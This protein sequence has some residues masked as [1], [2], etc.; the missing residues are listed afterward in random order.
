MHTPQFY[1]HVF[2]MGTAWTFLLPLAIV[3][4][5]FAKR[6]HHP[7]WFKLHRGLSVLALGLIVGAWIVG[8]TLMSTD[9]S[10]PHL[11][12]GTSAVF[13]AAIQPT[14]AWFRPSAVHGDKPSED[15]RE[16]FS[17]HAWVGRAAV[18]LGLSNVVIGFNLRGIGGLWI[19]PVTLPLGLIGVTYCVCE[20]K[21]LHKNVPMKRMRHV[22]VAPGSAENSSLLAGSV[23]AADLPRMRCESMRLDTVYLDD[24]NKVV[25]RATE[26]L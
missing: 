11:W 8:M 25:R 17:I 10:P 4:S 9:V 23:D 3:I 6:Y 13:L 12:V 22:S 2:F 14:I 7:L 16:W 1:V 21:G 18:L 26:V 5:R 15:R 19:I 24:A 20:W